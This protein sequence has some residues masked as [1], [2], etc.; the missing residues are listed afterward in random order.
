M[1]VKLTKANISS[2]VAFGNCTVYSM[3]GY[4]DQASDVYIQLH[5]MC[6]N[7]SVAPNPIGST[8]L[9]ATLLTQSKN[10]FKYE[11]VGGLNF[12]CLLVGMSTVPDTFTA[13]GAGGG[14]EV[15][16]EVGG[17]FLCNGAETIVGDLTTGCDYLIVQADSGPTGKKL[18]RMDYINADGAPRYLALSNTGIEGDY[19]VWFSKN[20]AALAVGTH[21]FLFGDSFMPVMQDTSSYA[22]HWGIVFMQLDNVNRGLT[23]SGTA[24]MRAILR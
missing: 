23:V 21:V 3:T 16:I 14:V 2:W 4:N 8:Y 20:G 7:S 1:R 15:E 22:L 6:P 9:K 11:W 19:L 10:G 17:V 13:V 18:L 5:E 12:S 24:K